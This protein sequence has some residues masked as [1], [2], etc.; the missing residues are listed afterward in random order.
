MVV[1]LLSNLCGQFIFV[2]VKYLLFINVAICDL[3]HDLET[4]HDLC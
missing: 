3:V 4:V 2:C 1:N